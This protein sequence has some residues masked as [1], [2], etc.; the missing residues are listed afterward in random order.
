MDGGGHVYTEQLDTFIVL[1]NEH[2]NL[3]G[4]N[5]SLSLQ[6]A[7]HCTGVLTCPLRCKTHYHSF[8]L[9]LKTAEPEITP[10]YYTNSSELFTE[11]RENFIK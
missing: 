2:H 8:Q 9:S 1:A 11:V 7:P 3:H 5:M 4:L 6:N 10:D